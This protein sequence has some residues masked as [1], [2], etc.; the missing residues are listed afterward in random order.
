[1]LGLIQDEIIE[2]DTCTCELWKQ[3]NKCNFFPVC[4][5]YSH[6]NHCNALRYRK[7]EMMSP[8]NP[9][10][11]FHDALDAALLCTEFPSLHVLYESHVANM[12][13]CR[14]MEDF[15]RIKKS[16]SFFILEVEHRFP[17][18]A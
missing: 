4:L 18:N 7:K 14:N 6:F 8:N 9:F 17:G 16:W 12:L 13:Y 2:H 15:L 11:H 5:F 10:S 1:M 3:P